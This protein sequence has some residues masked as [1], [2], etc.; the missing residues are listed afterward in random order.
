[1]KLL[2][3]LAAI[4]AINWL[5]VAFNWNLV[6]ALLG[7]SPMLVDA[8]YIVVGIAGVLLLVRACKGCKTCS[9]SKE[10]PAS[11]PAPEMGSQQDSQNS[12]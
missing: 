4:G 12:M 5:L 7:F 8:V 10:A 3:I 2:T 1:M 9:V 11:T 6:E